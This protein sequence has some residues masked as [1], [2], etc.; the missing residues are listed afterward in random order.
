MFQD[1]NENLKTPPQTPASVAEV[2][3]FYKTLRANNTV[4]YK[5]Q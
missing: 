3:H 5:Q 4:L 1:G 2:S